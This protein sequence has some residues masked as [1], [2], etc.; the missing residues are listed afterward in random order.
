MPAG[1]S[2][3]KTGD[4]GDGSEREAPQSIRDVVRGR[5]LL[6]WVL[7]GVLV[8]LLLCL[9]TVA[10]VGPGRELLSRITSGPTATSAI[11]ATDT[12]TSA[13]TTLL[14][15]TD[16]SIPTDTPV[17]TVT[18]QEPSHGAC[19]DRCD[20]AA[21]ACEAGLSCVPK[22]ANSNE[23]ICWNSAICAVATEQGTGGTPPS[24]TE[25]SSTEPPQECSPG[26]LPA[27]GCICCGT[28]LVCAD[29][30]VATFNPRCGVGS[31]GCVCIQYDC[32][33][34][35]YCV[36]WQNTCNGNTGSTCPP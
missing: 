32:P 10:A 6:Y 31:C 7:L 27:G 15:S 29:G 22:L 26:W 3:F 21:P 1:D 9:C 25:A 30:T 2:F 12:P 20:P 4:S 35:T 8:L 24:A 33:T 34:C 17:M 28:T 11:T 36:R 14:A 16:T 19:L 18:A 23:Y 5:R 13:D